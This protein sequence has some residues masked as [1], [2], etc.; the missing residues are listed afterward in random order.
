MIRLKFIYFTYSTLHMFLSKFSVCVTKRFIHAFYIF[1]MY[2][3]FDIN[4]GES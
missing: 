1:D 3:A 4:N 2:V